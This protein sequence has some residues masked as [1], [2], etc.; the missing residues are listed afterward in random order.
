MTFL[1]SSNILE[2]FGKLVPRCITI[3]S[4][5]N[6]QESNFQAI[7]FISWRSH[8]P[9]KC[10]FSLCFAWGGYPRPWE[11]SIGPK[12]VKIK[13]L[14]HR[15]CLG[16][17]FLLKHLFYNFCQV[18]GNSYLRDPWGYP[19]GQTPCA[20]PNLG[21]LAPPWKTCHALRPSIYA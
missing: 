13:R 6:G 16:G 5:G 20:C 19:P 11:A 9:M 10:W 3:Y 12:P 18:S 15:C 7:F 17:E 4:L 14:D 1:A 21:G 8:P 2:L